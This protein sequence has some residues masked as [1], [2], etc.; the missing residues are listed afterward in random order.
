MGSEMLVIGT[1]LTIWKNMGYWIPVFVLIC[2]QIV[3]GSYVT[4]TLCAALPRSSESG[5]CFSCKLLSS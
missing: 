2:L 3:R 4:R 1:S 5:H